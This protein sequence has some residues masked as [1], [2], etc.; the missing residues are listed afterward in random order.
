MA[1]L[2]NVYNAVMEKQQINFI[3]KDDENI[4]ID[5]QGSKGRLEVYVSEH[6]MPGEKYIVFVPDSGGSILQTSV[7]TLNIVN[8]TL[9]IITNKGTNLY[10]FK[11]LDDELDDMN[12]SLKMPEKFLHICEVCG[13]TEIISPEEAND[14]GW[15]YP[16][17]IGEF[18]VL[19][20]RTCGECGITDTLYWKVLNH[21]VKESTFTEKD[22][23]TIERIKGEP[24]ILIP[25]EEE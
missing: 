3:M 13:K 8:D 23:I 20:P 4:R 12:V 7:G 24:L 25:R 11:L 5:Y 14:R 19:S 10:V 16:P 1:R 9:S 6:K 22:Y 2:V 15:D 21:E 17:N 18:G